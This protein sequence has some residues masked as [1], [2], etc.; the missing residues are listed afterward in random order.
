MCLIPPS[1]I[2]T[3]AVDALTP[4]H[5]DEVAVIA[6][7]CTQEMAVF[8]AAR[9]RDGPGAAAAVLPGPGPWSQDP[10]EGGPV[11]KRS[12]SCTTQTYYGRPSPN[13][14]SRLGIGDR[15]LR[16]PRVITVPAPALAGAVARP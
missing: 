13:V 7:G 15:I 5:R 12:R 10:L 3:L 16:R 14:Q 6:P 11:A 8:L 2:A 4:C 9:Q 1:Q